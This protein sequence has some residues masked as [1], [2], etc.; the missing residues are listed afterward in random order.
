MLKNITPLGWIGIIILFNGTLVGGTNYLADLFLSP[1]IVKAIVAL[2]SLGN[3]FLGGLV[4]MFSTPMN[5]A[6]S[7]DQGTIVKSMLAMPGVQH[8]DVNAQANP[9]LAAIAVD[10]LNT[11]IAPTPAAA[12]TVA[13]TAKTA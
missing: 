3:M 2:A 7:A 1:T 13:E 12:A 11:K 9:T 5:L 10:P 8:I 4:T 6:K